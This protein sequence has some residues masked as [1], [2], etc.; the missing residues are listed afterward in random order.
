M[1]D[2]ISRLSGVKHVKD[3]YMAKCPAHADSTASL[4]VKQTDDGRILLHCFAGCS[5]EQVTHALGLTVRDLFATKDSPKYRLSH[6]RSG[7]ISARPD[8]VYDYT[9]REGHLL[10]QVCRY[11]TTDGKTFR[12]RHPDGSG[13]FINGLGDVPPVLYKLPEVRRCIEQGNGEI[14]LC[15]GEKDADNACARGFCA[16]TNAMGAGKWKKEY[17]AQLTGASGITIVPDNDKAGRAHAIL[18]SKAMTDAG[19]TAKILDLASL[20]PAFP[21]KGDLSDALGMLANI[22]DAPTVTPAEFENICLIRDDEPYDFNPTSRYLSGQFLIDLEKNKNSPVISTGF[23]SLDKQ[24]GGRIYSGLYILGSVSSLGKSAF[25]GQMADQIASQGIDVLYFTLEMSRFEMVSRWL[26]RQLFISSPEQYIDKNTGHIL[27]GQTSPKSL[28]D[29]DNL[30]G[31]AGEHLAYI[32]GNFELSAEELGKTVHKHIRHT[33]RKPVV[34]IDYLQILTSPD[35]RMSDKQATDH[36]VVFLKRLSREL[37]IPIFCVSSFN[38][39]SYNDD[40]SF[41]SFKES[42]AIEYSADFIFALQAR[43]VLDHI[44]TTVDE[45]KLAR[46]ISN[47]VQSSKNQDPRPLEAVILKNRRG[48][49]NTRF[50]LDY[51]PRQNY[52]VELTQ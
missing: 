6:S 12:I 17:T 34:F 22:A 25:C 1:T 46:L 47:T 43:G 29:T 7:T 2:F 50:P 5:T 26:I 39:Q 8:K 28:S 9:D 52:F 48:P 11:Q 42:G 45:R 38:R 33:G 3:G 16:T 27:Y 44:S 15:E 32:E 40:V 14:W 18:A 23:P 49:A 24:L 13:G 30:L 10:Y 35:P 36:N 4:S 37:D 51:Y 19:L 41:S 21:E 20:I 31:R